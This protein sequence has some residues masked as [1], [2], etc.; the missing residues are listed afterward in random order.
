MCCWSLPLKPSPMKSRRFAI[1]A[2]VFL[3]TLSIASTQSNTTNP[4]PSR[5]FCGETCRGH[6]DCDPAGPTHGPV[7]PDACLWCIR[8]ICQQGPKMNATVDFEELSLRGAVR[9]PLQP[10]RSSCGERCGAHGDCLYV[11]EW[12]KDGRCC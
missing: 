9:K 10:H 4:A 6:L 3:L 7:S 5:P 1:S 12:C 11:C 2:S 8:S